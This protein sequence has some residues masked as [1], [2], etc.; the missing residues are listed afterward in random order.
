MFGIVRLPPQTWRI[1]SEYFWKWDGMGAKAVGIFRRG[2]MSPLR[3][4][5]PVRMNGS[6]AQRRWGGGGWGVLFCSVSSMLRGQGDNEGYSG[7]RNPSLTAIP[8]P[9][10]PTSHTT[11]SHSTAVPLKTN[12]ACSCAFFSFSKPLKVARNARSYSHLALSV[13]CINMSKI[14]Q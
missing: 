9:N 8:N 10:A 1:T 2:Q 7:H 4:F 13:E 6:L 3:H 11:I 14:C 5:T 12:C